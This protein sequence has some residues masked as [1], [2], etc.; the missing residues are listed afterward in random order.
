MKKK[1]DLKKA[2]ARA[3]GLKPSSLAPALAYSYISAISTICHRRVQV[4]KKDFDRVRE[5][6]EQLDKLGEAYDSYA[7]TVVGAWH[8]WC[9]ERGMNTIPLN[10]FLGNAA[11]IRFTETRST[12]RLE[13]PGDEHWNMAVHGEMMAA[14][15]YVDA[16]LN[17]QI[18]DLN[19]ARQKAFCNSKPTKEV[20]SEVERLLAEIYGCSGS[21]DEIAAEL[22]RRRSERRAKMPIYVPVE[23]ESASE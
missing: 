11:W 12:V 2:I 4:G 10:I 21:Y 17:C 18:M 15:L 23:E 3:K 22:K 13:T 9:K 1:R 8:A 14:K 7:Y 5:R 16:R 20:I 6:Q 19:L